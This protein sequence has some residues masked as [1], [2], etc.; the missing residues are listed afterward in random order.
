MTSALDWAKQTLPTS[1][2]MRQWSSTTCSTEPFFVHL[3]SHQIQTWRDLEGINQRLC[4]AL[5]RPQSMAQCH[6]HHRHRPRRG[7]AQSR[8]VAKHLLS[9]EQLRRPTYRLRSQR[10]HLKSRL[11]RSSRVPSSSVWL[12]KDSPTKQHRSITR[13]SLLGFRKE[14]SHGT[15]S[16]D[17]S[18][19]RLPF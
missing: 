9:A 1:Q 3:L 14:M 13:A 6:L 19:G 15:R 8:R 17:S 12:P 16:E 5:Q 10:T 2:L 4:Q 7:R 18:L 11:P